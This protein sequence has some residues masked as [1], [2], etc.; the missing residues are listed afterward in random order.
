MVS[1][2]VSTSMASLSVSVQ[3]QVPEEA[4]R[5]T[6][7]QVVSELSRASVPI[8]QL[9]GKGSVAV[10]LSAGRVV[11]LAF[12][13]NGEN[14]LWSNPQLGDTELVKTTPAKLVGGYGGDRIW[15]SPELVYH[16][17]GQPDWRTFVN[18]K[19]PEDT[20]P[21]RYSF[22]GQ[23]PG[24]IAL[25]EKGRLPVRGSDR[26]VDFRV[27]RS[28]RLTEPPVPL[29][30][31]QMRGLQY[32]GIESVHHLSFTDDT[33]SGVLDLWHLLQV[34]KGSVIIVPLHA[35]HKTQLL[36][37][38]LPGLWEVRPD[39]VIFQV[40]GKAN[41]KIGI[42]AEA[43]TGRSAVLQRLGT[44]RWCLL[45]R[46]F[47]VDPAAHYGDH[48]YGVQRNDQ[49][50]QAWDGEGF[51][52]MEYHTPLLDAKDGPRT[53]RDQ[54]EL[55]AFGGGAN[56]IVTLART[57]LNVDVTFAFAVAQTQAH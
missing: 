57:L 39:S 24:V 30:D 45:V 52:E 21:G 33:R 41:A 1:V 12:T 54:D 48:P 11:A 6:Y 35:G 5:A 43:L 10:T 38:G 47:P 4:G 3:G 44:D 56:E 15:F 51:G 28:I 55:W 13:K 50:F 49:V 16:W 23:T 27:D 36:S 40:T 8:K 32:V 26:H 14:L 25:A 29:D 46:Q 17:L 19:A 37:Y 22:L 2:L 9:H 31:P 53:L 34:P 18:Y 7:S 42:A 20:D